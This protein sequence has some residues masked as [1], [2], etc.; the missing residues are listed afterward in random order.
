[1]LATGRDPNAQG[2]FEK[3][4]SPSLGRSTVPIFQ[5][6]ILRI[7]MERYAADSSVMCR[8]IAWSVPRRRARVAT[9]ARGQAG[10]LGRGEAGRGQAGGGQAGGG[11]GVGKGTVDGCGDRDD[12]DRL[13]MGRLRRVFT[14]VVT[15]SVASDGLGLSVARR[16]RVLPDR[17]CL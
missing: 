13:P 7:G 9:L 15:K 4:P 5:N 10:G 17:S 8:S 16:R 11:A 12:R 3:I 1:M 2:A 14:P 6:S